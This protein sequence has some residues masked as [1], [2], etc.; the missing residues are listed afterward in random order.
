M[1]KEYNMNRTGKKRRTVCLLACAA[2]FLACGCAG[3]EPEMRAYPMAVSIDYQE[4][5]YT[6]IYGMADLPADTGQG[7]D[8]QESGQEQNTGSEFRGRDM[9]EIQRLYDASQ[10]YELD[11]GHVQAVILGDGLLDDTEATNYIF[12]YMEN[13]VVLGKS[14]YLFRMEEPAGLMELNGDGTI[15]NYLTG[16][17][18]NRIG[19]GRERPLTL[20]N[21]FYEWNNYRRLPEIPRVMVEEGQ[22]FL[23]KSE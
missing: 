5:E 10:E 22:I 18:D 6:V 12:Q 11:L 15:G 23:D 14:A 19:G 16:L 9:D 7:K 2:A 4:G 3:V 17:Y 21:C 1:K 8:D 20:E 13:S